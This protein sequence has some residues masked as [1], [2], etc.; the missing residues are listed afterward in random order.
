MTGAGSEA[1]GPGTGGQGSP[2]YLAQHIRD[3]LATDPRVLELGLEVA[4]VGRTVVLRGSVATAAQRDAAVEVAR[5]LAPGAEILND[6]EVPPAP[7]PC[8]AE[9]IG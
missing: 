1:P 9:E 8:E 3:A 7:E 4:V 5:E 6:V 2:E